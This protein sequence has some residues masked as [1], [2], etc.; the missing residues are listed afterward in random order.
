MDIENNIN[1]E[2]ELFVEIVIDT[3]DDDLSVRFETAL[4]LINT[5]ELA[6]TYVNLM[7]LSKIGYSKF[8]KQNELA[9]RLHLANDT[10]YKRRDELAKLGLIKLEKEGKKR[11][12]RFRKFNRLQ[13]FKLPTDPQKYDTYLDEQIKS[14]RPITEEDVKQEKVRQEQLALAGMVEAKAIEIVKKEK[15]VAKAKEP[16][17]KNEDY[18]SV[19]EAY[20]KN[21]GVFIL[22]GS[23][24]EMRIKKSAKLMFLSGHTVIEIIECCRFFGKYS[25]KEGYE[26]MSHW[27]IETVAKKMPEF[28]AGKLKVKEMGDDLPDL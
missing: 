2:N 21:K 1:E 3:T 8:K 18:I 16:K 11:I 24:D 28:K 12:I 27:T 6:G 15:E 13:K 19:I 4:Y 22:R 17:F 7:T 23:P 14:L 20:R 5:T 25:G 26:W 9:Q 10:Y